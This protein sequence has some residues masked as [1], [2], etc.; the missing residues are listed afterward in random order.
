M[1]RNAEI[2]E[3]LGFDDILLMPRE[4]NVKPA[5]VLI[6]TR[7][8][9]TISLGIPLIAAGVD[10]V[11]ESAMAVAIA[12]LGG[13]G[14]IHDNMPLGKQVEEVR[15]VKRSEG[16]MVMNPITIAQEASVAEALDLMT[17]YRVSGLPVI[18]QSSQKVVGIITSR[19]IRFFED[20][21]K[22]VTELMTRE[23]VTV[24]G[25]VEKEMAKRMLHQH[26]IE[27]LVVVDEQ[28][29]CVGLVTVRDIE[30]LSRFPDAARD[31]LGRLRVG[32]AVGTGKDAFDRTAAMTDAG[33]DV[34]FIDAAHG[35]TRDAISTV[36][37]IRQQRSSAVQIVAGNVV[38][39][40]AARSLVDAGADAIRVGVGAGAG[41]ASRALAGVG[42]P[43][44]KAVLDVVEQCG[45]MDVPVIVAGGVE[46]PAAVAK[47]IA[48]GAESVVI[49][50][51][52]AGTDEAPGEI[53][54]QGGIVYKVVNPAARAQHRPPNPSGVPDPYRFDE[55]PVDTSVPYRGGVAHM[56]RHLVGGLKSAMAYTGS[57]D[58]PAMIENAEFVRV[59]K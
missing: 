55:D 33:L 28:G 47:A 32:A 3:A 12:Q 50:R 38:T 8:T 39:A 44:L 43:Q 51:L 41:S 7:L 56:V 6:G 36:S 58:I 45:M 17:T 13:I 29:R 49:D 11:T 30:K 18:E 31:T 25:P 9:K 14:I 48:A 40:D 57:K 34:V 23:V 2:H 4:T 16:D 21:A 26:R 1:K 54:C 46:S 53:V 37:H 35:H 59:N 20:Y 19:D 52:F 27:K 22:P 15:R 42:M 5:D 10:Y 24:E